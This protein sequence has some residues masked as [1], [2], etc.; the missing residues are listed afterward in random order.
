M[1]QH[2][3]Y[4]YEYYVFGTC[5][6]WKWFELID[7][8]LIPLY[9][10]QNISKQHWEKNEDRSQGFEINIFL[11]TNKYCKKL[12]DEHDNLFAV[13]AI[14]SSCKWDVWLFK[15]YLELGNISSWDLPEVI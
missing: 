4:V 5:V 11:S 12:L 6:P 2:Y 9:I 10:A 15:Y 8:C 13:H 1:Q 3:L 7:I 14:F